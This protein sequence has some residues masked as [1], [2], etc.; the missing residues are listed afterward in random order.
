MEG[1]VG[2]RDRSVESCRPGDVDHCAGGRRDEQAVYLVDL[3][4]CER[5]GMNVHALAKATAGAAIAG[6][7]DPVEPQPPRRHAVENGRRDMAEHPVGGLA[8]VAHRGE[9]GVLRLVLW[10]RPGSLHIRTAAEPEELSGPLLPSQV[11]I[12]P[13][14]GE[15]LPTR[16]KTRNVHAGS[17]PAGRSRRARMTKLGPRT[18]TFA[19]APELQLVCEHRS[20]CV[21]ALP[22]GAHLGAVGQGLC[23]AGQ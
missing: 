20:W 22:N 15:E 21:T 13:A 23:L 18:P 3:V 7:V 8:L 16:N 12:G 19:F 1:A 6:A 17:I 9:Q 11:V 5:R 4:G 14:C 2:R 10:R